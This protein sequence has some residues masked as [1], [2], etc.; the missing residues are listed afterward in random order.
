MRKLIMRIE[1]I[2][3]IEWMIKRESKDWM[4]EWI[5][6]YENR[7]NKRIMIKTKYRTEV[8]RMNIGEYS[9]WETYVEEYNE[10]KNEYQSRMNFRIK[11]EMGE[12]LLRWIR[13]KYIN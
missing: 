11:I 1:W 5:R 4:R 9:E 2:F 12:Y 8:G 10:R 6:G 3:R 13:I 7:M